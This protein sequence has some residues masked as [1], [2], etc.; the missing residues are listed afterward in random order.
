MVDFNTFM[1]VGLKKCAP[2]GPGSQ[3][4][5]QETFD[6]L[7]EVWNREK[8]EIEAMSKAEVRRNLTCP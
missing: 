7:V 4:G 5:R 1:S 6:D 2:T 8:D 3:S